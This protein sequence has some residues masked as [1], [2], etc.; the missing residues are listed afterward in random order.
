[1]PKYFQVDAVV[2]VQPLRHIGLV[3]KKGSYVVK[4]EIQKPP[5]WHFFTFL[6]VIVILMPHFIIIT[7]IMLI[8][9]ITVILIFIT[10]FIRHDHPCNITITAIK[11]AF[12]EM[13]SEVR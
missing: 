1:M 10:M 5:R 6:L 13:K 8:I 2:V 3:P 4:E 11:I 12:P 9:T 7:I